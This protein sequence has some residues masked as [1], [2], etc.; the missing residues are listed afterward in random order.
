MNQEAAGMAQESSRPTLGVVAISR[1]ERRDIEGFIA[2]LE[3]WV[4][5]IIIVD[6]GSTDGTYELLRDHGGKVKVMQR[7]LD[8]AA[9]GFGAQRN[10]GLD[11]ASTDWVLH[12]DIDERVTPELAAEARQAIA[13]TDHDAFRYHRLNFFLHR[14]FNAGGWQTWNAPQLGRRGRHRFTGAIHETIEVDGGE[15]RIGQLQSMMWHLNDDGY[16]ERM[17]KNAQYAQFSA[18]EILRQ[19]VRIGWRHLVFVP[20]KRA[21]KSYLLRGAW[22]HG[23]TGLL[24]SLYVFCGT[25]NWYAIAWDRQ[26][27][28][29][30]SQIEESLQQQW[31]NWRAAHGR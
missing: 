21:L 14:P 17:L 9:G 29:P 8:R 4:D 15:G 27:Q 5:E 19:P 1:N 6:D 25:F 16:V 30:R 12:M 10:A 20:L 23:E 22:R 13:G 11:Q 26:R 7:K 24:F 28:I 3:S 31:R 18:D 2:N